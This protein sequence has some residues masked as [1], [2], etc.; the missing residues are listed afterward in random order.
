MEFSCKGD[1]G[2]GNKRGF[3]SRGFG[4]GFNVI[5]SSWRSIVMEMMFKEEDFNNC[6][7]KKM[8]RGKVV[9]RKEDVRRV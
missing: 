6:V 1:S 2:R 9:D 4:G 8:V 5:G 7:K 3:W